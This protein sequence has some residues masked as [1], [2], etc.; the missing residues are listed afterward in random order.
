MSNKANRKKAESYLISILIK[1]DQSPKGFNV[2]RYKKLFAEM[3]DAKFDSWMKA[4]RDGKDCIY[5]YYPNMSK[6]I[7]MQD[8]LK[9]FDAEGVE[10]FHRIKQFDKITGKHFVSNAKYPICSLFVRRLQQFRDKKISASHDDTKIDILTG[11]TANTATSDKPATLTQPEMQA[12]YSK[13][14]GMPATLHELVAIRGGNISAW[15]GG[16][17]QQGEEHGVIRLADIEADSVNRTVVVTQVL[18]NG[19]GLANNLLGD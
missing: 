14:N 11:Q 5:V 3:S 10:I 15:S 2:E 19:M 12:L 1:L 7:N 13:Y 16:M 17:K 8:M 9:V 6:Q 4:I 18:L